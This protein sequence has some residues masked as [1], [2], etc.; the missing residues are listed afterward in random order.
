MLFWLN[1]T[2]FILSRYKVTQRTHKCT[3]RANLEPKPDEPIS[4][5]PDLIRNFQPS[6]VIFNSNPQEH[7]SQPV[8][9]DRKVYRQPSSPASSHNIYSPYIPPE[10]KQNLLNF[11]R[12][13]GKRQLG[14]RLQNILERS[15]R[16]SAVVPQHTQPIT[17]LQDLSLIEQNQVSPAVCQVDR[18]KSNKTVLA[19]FNQ[20]PENNLLLLSNPGL[21]LPLVE[22]RDMDIGPD[23]TSQNASINS[24]QDPGSELTNM[25][26]LNSL[27][28]S[29]PGEELNL[30]NLE[31]LLSSQIGSSDT[32]ISIENSIDDFDI[33]ALHN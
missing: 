24:N 22:S 33:S 25:V 5:K 23:L 8:I 27:T 1:L 6:P 19:L 20:N 26:T 16:K 7:Q 14:H 32:E 18:D 29:N 11:R 17:E 10:I 31:I 4:P 9:Q 12:A 2:G 21:N 3:G 28:C 30:A 15:R 13:Q